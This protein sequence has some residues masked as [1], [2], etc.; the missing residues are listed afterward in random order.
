MRKPEHSRRGF[1]VG[2]A[3]AATAVVLPFRP[4]S[5]GQAATVA[6]D[7]SVDWKAVRDEFDLDPRWIH[8]SSFFLVSHPRPVRESIE[9]WRRKIDENP[10]WLEEVLFHPGAPRMLDTIRKPLAAY[11][12]GRPEEIA[13]VPNTTTGLALVYNGLKIRRG[14]EILTTTHDHYSHLE[15]IRLAAEKAGASM[16]QIALHD[17]AAKASESE[18]AE[19]LRRAIGAKTRAVGVTWVHSSTGLKLPIPTLAQVVAAANRGRASQDRCLFVV[20]GVHGLGAAR[21][22]VAALGADFVVAGTHKWLFGPRGTGLI[23]GRSDAWPEVRPTVPTFDSLEPFDDWIAR[24]PQG[25]TRAGYVSPGGFVA[26]EHFFALPEAIAFHD[27]LGRERVAARIDELNGRMREEMAR[28][29]KVRLHTP[30]DPRLAAGLVCF[31]VDGKTPEAVVERLREKRILAS[32]SPYAVSYARVAA[33]IMV[34][35]EEV[36]STL[37]AIHQT[38]GS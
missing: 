10:L 6:S 4:S 22:E 17:G 30:R 16:R 7:G 2:L 5:L 3:G 13:L 28:M 26:Y 27:R 32:T 34:S 23:W 36:E 37:A 21:E 25:P 15:S 18:M 35:P 20:D 38:A 8:M 12:G 29:P 31:E 1:L 24:K 9:L 14:Q 33:G 11:L 19:R